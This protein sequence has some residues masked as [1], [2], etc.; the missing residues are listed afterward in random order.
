MAPLFFPVEITRASCPVATT[1]LRHFQ[2]KSQSLRKARPIMVLE[3][4]FGQSKAQTQQ[5]GTQIVYSSVLEQQVP[6]DRS[7]DRKAHIINTYDNRYEIEYSQKYVKK[8]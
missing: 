3:C 5:R 6:A 2:Q 7:T 1:L 8:H 4:S